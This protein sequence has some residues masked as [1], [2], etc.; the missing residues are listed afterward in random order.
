MLLPSAHC[1]CTVWT[2]CNFQ[3]CYTG[4]H[5][6]GFVPLLEYF[7][8]SR[9]GPGAHLVVSRDPCCKFSLALNRE[10]CIS[11]LCRCVRVVFLVVLQ[12]RKVCYSL[13]PTVGV[14]FSCSAIF[15]IATRAH[16]V[17]A[18]FHCS[19]T[20]SIPAR[21]QGPTLWYPSILFVNI[22]S[23]RTA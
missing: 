3:N 18:L 6:N 4:I 23:R 2:L 13:R 1:R 8:D 19:S 16:I 17:T 20:F 21:V 22:P 7:F 12:S 14:L 5:C 15:K 11:I 10:T 9:E